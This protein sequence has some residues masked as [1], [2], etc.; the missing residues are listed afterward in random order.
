MKNF[1]KALRN[2]A[3]SSDLGNASTL[4]RKNQDL[5]KRKQSKHHGRQGKPIFQIEGFESKA[6]LGGDGISSDE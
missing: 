5:G 2:L 6:R 4:L 1:S 3:D